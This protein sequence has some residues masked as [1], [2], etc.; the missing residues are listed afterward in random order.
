MNPMIYKSGTYK[1]P[2]IYKGAGGIYKGCGVY[3]DG[4]VDITEVE[5]GGRIY[6]VVK[7]NGNYWLAQNLD[8]KWDGLTI[9]STS[10]L[11]TPC[12]WYY[13]NDE[14]T[15]GYDGQYK[16]G[17]MYNWYAIRYI[18]ENNLIPGW[19]IPKRDVFINAYNS[20]GGDN[21]ALKKM[22]CVDNFLNNW[23]TGWNGNGE[24]GLNISP[25][26]WRRDTTR[27]EDFGTWANYMFSDDRYMSV[28]IWHANALYFGQSNNLVY[29]G[30]QCISGNYIFLIK[31]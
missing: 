4:A 20:L 12:A 8:F 11:E 21:D 22:K 6:P 5:I 17:L 30:Y 31:D 19:H 27:F 13:N 2:C 3:N 14:N 1:S 25:C 15:Y 24:S 29:T 18:N 23:P 7:I 10:D 16:A 26:G 9:G 28:G